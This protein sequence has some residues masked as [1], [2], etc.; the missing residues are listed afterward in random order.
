MRRRDALIAAAFLLASACALAED[1]SAVV[2]WE[3]L[4]QVTVTKQKD[5]YVPEFSRQIAALDKREVK[6][7]GFMLPLEQGARQKHFLLVRDESAGFS[8]A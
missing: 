4:A 6:L 2:P 1:R 8:T 7:R 5:R 3:A